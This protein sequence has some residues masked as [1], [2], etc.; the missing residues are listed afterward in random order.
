MV[1]IM[2]VKRQR[3]RE[4]E[5]T[6]VAPASFVPCILHSSRSAVPRR[7]RCGVIA[8]CAPHA[9]EDGPS[10]WCHTPPVSAEAWLRATR[11]HYGGS[12]VRTGWTGATVIRDGRKTSRLSYDGARARQEKALLL[13]F[14]ASL[15]LLCDVQD[16]TYRE[17]RQLRRIES[18]RPTAPSQ[19]AP[20]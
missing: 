17:Q 7:R 20:S 1:R 11:G 2:R 9:V 6:R 18:P 12:A 3:D 10:G 14:D 15:R 19:Q 5:S 16:A 8:T 13:P 4:R